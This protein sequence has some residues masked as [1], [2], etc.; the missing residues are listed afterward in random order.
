MLKYLPEAWEEFSQLRKEYIQWLNNWQKE[1]YANDELNEDDVV[2][3]IL[4][5]HTP[6]L[7]IRVPRD[8]SERQGSVQF[9]DD[10]E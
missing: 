8:E 1:L 5:L 7:D 10:N 9:R 3:K 2:H 4:A 6:S